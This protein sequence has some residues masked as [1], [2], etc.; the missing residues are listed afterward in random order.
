L[1][2]VPIVNKA[3]T[4]NIQTTQISMASRVDNLVLSNRIKPGMFKDI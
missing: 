4:R 3:T 1:V 2:N